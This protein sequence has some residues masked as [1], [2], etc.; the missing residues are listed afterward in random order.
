MG[1]VPVK[2]LPGCKV[3]VQA[4]CHEVEATIPYTMIFASGRKHKGVW[5]GVAYTRAQVKYS[6]E[7]LAQKKPDSAKTSKSK[8]SDSAKTSKSKTSKHTLK[9][10]GNDSVARSSPQGQA[11]S[12]I[13]SQHHVQ[14][15][16][17]ERSGSTYTGPFFSHC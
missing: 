10:R 14:L 2:C 5:K 1:A 12:C 3:V 7:K 17:P 15:C 6:E 8:T 4:V 11:A 9:C 16:A 13:V